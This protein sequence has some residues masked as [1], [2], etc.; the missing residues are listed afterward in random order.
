MNCPWEEEFLGLSK[1]VGKIEIFENNK[2]VK[3]NVHMYTVC[4]M[5]QVL[6]VQCTTVYCMVASI[7]NP[8]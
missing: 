8:R 4:A 1:F 6:Y 3:N 2:N 7:A 5:R